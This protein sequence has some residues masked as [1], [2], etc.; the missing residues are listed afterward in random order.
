MFYMFSNVVTVDC[1]SEQFICDNGSTCLDRS[2][3]CNSWPQCQDWS[4]DE[5]CGMDNNIKFG[6]L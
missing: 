4:D 2:M 5:S 3:V 6:I 1:L